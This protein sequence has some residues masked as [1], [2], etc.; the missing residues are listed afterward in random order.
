MVIRGG[1][2]MF[3]LP[4]N[5]DTLSTLDVPGSSVIVNQEG[6]SATTSYVSTNNNYLTSANTIGNPFP[7]GF[8]PAG[9]GRPRRQHQSRPVEF[10]TTPQ[11]KGIP[12]HCAGISGF[13]MR[14]LRICFWRWT[15]SAITRSTSPS[16]VR[17]STTS[18]SNFLS[19]MP[20][21]DTALVA[22]YSATVKNPFAGLASRHQHQRFYG[23]RFSIV[24]HISAIY[25][26]H[27]AKC[28]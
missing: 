23:G 20:K 14:F 2:S 15:T 19:T 21:R 25:R 24:A 6:F 4:S 12:T 13:S 22:A 3:V 11:F 5:L 18:R 10:T 8:A 7:T 26:S 16:P 9:R 28:D 27:R 1:F 17:R